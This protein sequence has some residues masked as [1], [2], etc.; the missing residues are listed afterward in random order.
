MAGPSRERNSSRH[1]RLRSWQTAK[2][3]SVADRHPS[4]NKHPWEVQEMTAK[5]K[6][7]EQSCKLAELR[8]LA[9]HKR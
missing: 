2:P 8:R 6:L 5:D 4:S 9:A 1:Q 7:V 3:L